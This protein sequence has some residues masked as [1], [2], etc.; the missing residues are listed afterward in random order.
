MDKH[1][2]IEFKDEKMQK[3][4]RRILFFIAPLI[5]LLSLEVMHIAHLETLMRFFATGYFVQKLILS[6]VF[7]LATQCLFYTLTQSSF[8]SNLINTVLMFGLVYASEALHGFCYTQLSDVEQEING[9][10]TYDRE[11]KCD[12][13]KIKEINDMY[14]LNVVTNR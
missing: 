7:L 1:F 14:H 11:P 3:S 10:L 5:L 9:L 8:Y 12:V 4:V 13:N 2:Y 6:Y